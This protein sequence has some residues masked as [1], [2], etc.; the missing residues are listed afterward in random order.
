MQEKTKC[1]EFFQCE[2]RDCPVLEKKEHSC[3][4]V[5]GTHCRNEI[6]GKFLEKIEMC[7]DCKPFKTNIALGSLEDTLKLVHEQ[8]TEFRRMVDDR[9]RELEDISLELAIGLSE[10]FEAL[11][12]ISSGDPDAR[13]PLDDALHQLGNCRD[14]VLAIVDHEHGLQIADRNSFAK[15]VLQHPLQF[16]DV[17]HL[18]YNLLHRLGRFLSLG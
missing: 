10:V 16:P 13:T 11:K 5:S 15:Q 2:E 12:R 6:Q 1:W 9:D 18:R 17:Y 14:P 4:L 7:L 8:F 3:W